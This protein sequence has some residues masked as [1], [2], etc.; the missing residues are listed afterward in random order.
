MYDDNIIH[1][2]SYNNY[3]HLYT[4]YF[5]IVEFTNLYKRY[6]K[7]INWATMIHVVFYKIS[8]MFIWL[9]VDIHNITAAR[10]RHERKD[11]PQFSKIHQLLMSSLLISP[12]L[13]GPI[14]RGKSELRKPQQWVFPTSLHTITITMIFILTIL[15]HSVHSQVIF[16]SDTQNWQNAE[17]DC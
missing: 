16:V 8:N 11:W 15:I 3:I 9:M 1:F 5:I 14:G 10:Q 2:S 13:E 4:P 12:I 7:C 6:I 17:N